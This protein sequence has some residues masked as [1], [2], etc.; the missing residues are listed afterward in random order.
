MDNEKISLLCVLSN[1]YYVHMQV[2]TPDHLHT[3]DTVAFPSYKKQ[4]RDTK[5]D[6][7]K[8]W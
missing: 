5:T 7:H 1:Q 6:I 8:L 3:K 2:Q 4:A